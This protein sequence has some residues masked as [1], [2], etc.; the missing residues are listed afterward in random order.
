MHEGRNADTFR[1]NFRDIEW[2]KAPRIY[3]RYASRRVLT[4][5]YLPGIKI[6]HYESLE[7]AGLDR[8]RL[9]QLGAQAYL[10]QLLNDGFFHAV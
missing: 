4:L 8:Q 7:A 9:A 2:V 1:R 5:E 3:W 10:H 6:S